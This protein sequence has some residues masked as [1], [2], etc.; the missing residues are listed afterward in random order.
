MYRIVVDK[1]LLRDLELLKGCVLK[2]AAMGNGDVCEK[3]GE[4]SEEIS[5]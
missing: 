1:T 4:L 2:A 3:S 5:Q